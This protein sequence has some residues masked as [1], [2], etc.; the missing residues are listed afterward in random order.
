MKLPARSPRRWPLRL[1]AR[2]L[3]CVLIA[4]ASLGAGELLAEHHGR[5]IRHEAGVQALQQARDM[6][7]R[8]SQE[9]SA[10]SG[11]LLRLS[12]QDVL[13]DTPGDAGAVRPVLEQLKAALPHCTWIGLADTHGTVL[14]ATDDLLFGGSI[15]ARPMFRNGSLGPWTGEAQEAAATG[16][17]GPARFVDMA[18]PVRDATAAPRGVVAMRMGWQ[19]IEE[20]RRAALGPRG[21][22][23]GTE[24]LVLAADGRVL[25]GPP[26]GNGP[27]PSLVPLALKALEG[28]FGVERWSDGQDAVTGV[29]PSRPHAD[30]LGLGWRV[31][32]RD[33]AAAARAE[34]GETRRGSLPW[35]LGLGS[36][37]MLL[38][39]WGIGR[40]LPAAG[41]LGVEIRQRDPASPSPRPTGAP[42]QRRTDTPQARLQAVSLKP[43]LHGPQAL[44][45]RSRTDPLTGLYNRAGLEDAAG[46]LMAGPADGP[47]P[48]RELC[49]LCLDLDGVASIND[50]YGREAG[51]QVLVQAAKRLRHTAREGDL[52]FRLGDG[53]FMLLLACPAGEGPALSKTVAAR[54][55]ADLK[56]P[57]AYRTLSN[58][59][60]DCSLGAAVWPLHGT[61]L[62]EALRHAQEAM[63]AARTGGDGRFRL[64]A[65]Q[66]DRASPEVPAAQ[67]G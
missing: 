11:D 23:A 40:A 56:R 13:R 5:R 51:D 33:T 28:R 49:L 45:S 48:P 65:T 55:L 67:A 19:W 54:V 30:F 27:A 38:A 57:M 1:Q 39:W 17:A 44:E 43:L 32:V 6:A 25:L 61:T 34:P 15:A 41:T 53:E 31:V 42:L 2:G 60:L 26:E 37:C 64:H 66:D 3:A 24:M 46:R 4:A 36:L 63:R 12:Q 52:A 16:S 62:Q 10:R 22:L 7:D 9:M 58:L 20:S 35:S 8:L 50:R 21:A 18:A 47:L 29:A 59:H 14:A